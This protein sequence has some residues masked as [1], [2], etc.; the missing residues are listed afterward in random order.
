MAIEVFFGTIPAD[1]LY[2]T[3]HDMWVQRDGAS[4]VVGA[5]A[6]G[7]FL[8]GKAIAF[9]AKPRGAEVACGR[10]LGTV[11]SSKTVV[12]VHSPVSLVL[13]ETNE[14]AEERPQL[15]NDAPY[16][17]GWMVRG[18]PLAWD[19]ESPDLVDA[20]TYAAHVRA[21]NPGAI[22]ELVP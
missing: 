22:V 4:V 20:A 18:R 2:D 11:E 21:M 9:T 15:I 3:R 10:G 17:A 8:A 16:G 7:V 1:R 6:F 13:D 12:A 19:G 5:T 14:A